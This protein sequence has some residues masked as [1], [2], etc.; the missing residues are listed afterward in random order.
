MGQFN[1]KLTHKDAN[2]EQEV[3]VIR[4]LQNNLL[5]LPAISALN[6][7]H[8]IQT[9]Y[10][11]D[12]FNQFPEVFT[13]LGNL[14]Q[15]YQIQLKPDALPFALHTSQTVP[16]PLHE[17]VYEELN[18]MERGGVI[19]KVDEPTPWCSGLMVVSKKSGTIRIYVDLKKLNES[20]MV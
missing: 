2:A 1:A 17:K 4:G 10:A 12:I 18:R 16:L 7:L 9:T 3:F 13:G 20:V 14:G 19:S 6:L 8:R 5:G 11:D 15:E